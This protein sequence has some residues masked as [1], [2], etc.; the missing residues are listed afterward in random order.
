MKR[1]LILTAMLSAM[2]TLHAQGIKFGLIAGVDVSNPTNGA[3]MTKLGYR[4]GMKAESDFSNNTFLNVSVLLASKGY[5]TPV[6]YDGAAHGG[7]LART[8]PCYAEV[9]IHFGYKLQTGNSVKLFADLGP[10]FGIGIFGKSLHVGRENTR[11]EQ[12]NVFKNELMNRLDFGA[13]VNIGAEFWGKCQVSVGYDWGF[14]D[15]DH[16]QYSN[17]NSKNRVFK[18]TVTCFL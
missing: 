8:N 14:K 1:T 5:K 15:I 3:E 4:F 17:L 13:G 2:V 12:G 11:F 18:V 6:Y 9:P 16:E 7:G 10:Y